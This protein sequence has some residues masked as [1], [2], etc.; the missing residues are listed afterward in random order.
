[1]RNERVGVW[2]SNVI[3]RCSLRAC[4][5]RRLVHMYE[6]T[7]R[8]PRR[9]DQASSAIGVPSV[10]VRCSPS[11]YTPPGASAVARQQRPL[12]ERLSEC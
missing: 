7:A 11:R 5:S 3:P 8:C 6:L 2:M 10:G 1:M 12:N 4:M 9:A